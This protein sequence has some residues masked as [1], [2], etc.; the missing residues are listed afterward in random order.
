MFEESENVHGVENQL[1]QNLLANYSRF[2]RPISDVSKP[3]QVS[4]TF[5]LT[6]LMSLVSIHRYHIRPHQPCT[7]P[8]PA[9]TSPE[10]ILS[11]TWPH[12]PYTCPAP[13]HT[14]STPVMHLHTPAL[15]LSCTCPH[16]P[17]TCHAPAHTR[18]TPVM[19][20][21]TPALH[22]SCTCPHTPYTCPAPGH[23][24]PTPVLHLPT[25]TLHL[26]CTHPTIFCPLFLSCY[27]FSRGF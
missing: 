4:I 23:T 20:L 14:S 16:Q 9:H 12:T 11:C 17:Y 26:S 21:P 22:L 6:Q 18:P 15:H 5:Y 1:I 7:C 8:T 10:P 19:H 27:F 24:R 13:A 2:G 3:V 25:H